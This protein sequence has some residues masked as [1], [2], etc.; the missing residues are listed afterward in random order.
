MSLTERWGEVDRNQDGDEAPEPE[1]A[2]ARDEHS[3][4]WQVRLRH[5]PQ[6][7]RGQ[8]SLPRCHP[9]LLQLPPSLRPAGPSGISS[10]INSSLTDCD[11]DQ[12]DNLN[13]LVTI[14]LAGWTKEEAEL[15]MKQTYN[16]VDLLLPEELVKV[17]SVLSFRVR[18]QPAVSYQFLFV[19]VMFSGTGG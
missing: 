4:Q 3:V 13:E 14:V 2:P 5:R 11:I 9:R 8:L 1:P 17:E 18:P 15:Y 12:V 7:R 10:N 6:G 16:Q 19:I